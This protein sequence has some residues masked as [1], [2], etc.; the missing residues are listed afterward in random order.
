MPCLGEGSLLYKAPSRSKGIEQQASECHSQATSMSSVAHRCA[1]QTCF[2]LGACLLS[3][4]DSLRPKEDS[5]E[6]LGGLIKPFER[7]RS[8]RNTDLLCAFLSLDDYSLYYQSYD[9][10]TPDCWVGLQTSL[11]D[12]PETFGSLRVWEQLGYS[13]RPREALSSY[14]KVHQEVVGDSLAGIV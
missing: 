5:V 2:S 9:R 8:D 1:E 7:A 12:R 13:D 3:P 6:A 4:C 11:R 14:A 10:Q